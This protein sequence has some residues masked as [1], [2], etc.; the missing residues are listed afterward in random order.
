[1]SESLFDDPFVGTATMSVRDLAHL[2]ARSLDQAFPDDIWVIGEISSLT[3]SSNGH[4]Y[5]DLVEPADVPGAPVEA[6]LAVVLFSAT[7]T[8]V[9]QS[10]KKS[11][12]MRM[13]DGM[14]VRIRAALD[15]Y[16]P[17]GRLQLRMTGIDPGY[18]LGAL[19]LER[20]ALLRRLR[21][22]GLTER[23]AARPLPLVPLRVG[24]VTSAN[25][26]AAADFIT[27]LE[28][29]GFAWHV[30]LC[31]TRV[32]GPGADSSLARAVSE[33]ARRDLDAIALVR[34][35]GSKGDLIPFD[36]EELAR[37]IAASPVPVLTGIGHEID[38]SVADDVAHLAAK[39]PT[40][41]AA[42]LVDR[43]RSFTR[44]LEIAAAALGERA[45]RPLAIAEHRLERRAH[46][47]RSGAQSALQTEV[48]FLG[49]ASGR[50]E[51]SSRRTLDRA[52]TLL[53][54]RPNEL[55]ARCERRLATAERHLGHVDS[56]VAALDPR[57]MLARG[58]SIT[59]DSSGHAVRSVTAV[60]PGDILTTRLAD[61]AV[62]STVQSTAAP[63][64]TPGD[65]P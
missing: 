23:N 50:I 40:A 38:R 47:I 22:E 11:G 51:R 7:R 25:S 46:R 31:D 61:G 64:P 65:R 57:R 34:G 21:A 9:N 10:L 18:T 60:S 59:T 44:L 2:V 35:G 12:G 33:L 28:H 4:V 42:A 17:Q 1:M 3:R 14:R 53:A 16:A 63:T 39:T 58:W 41:C 13:T 62:T 30:I 24:L 36:A 32:Q 20:E 48:A 55:A 27:E 43:V 15:F 8:L 52:D 5:F 56:Q 19:A 54:Q 45:P 26:A 37:A 49:G 6:R 29:S